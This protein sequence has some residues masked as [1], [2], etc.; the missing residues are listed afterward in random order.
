MTDD[1]SSAPTPPT[2]PEAPVAPPASGAPIPPAAPI[3]PPAPAPVEVKAHKKFLRIVV[4]VGVA[5]V[6]LALKL[7]VVAGIAGIFHHEHH[8]VGDAENAVRTFLG[9]ESDAVADTQLVGGSMSHVEVDPSCSVLKGL[10][11]GWK[12]TV[13]SS[14]KES[15]GSA[16]VVVSIVGAD[17]VS[18]H[19]VH[20]SGTWLIDSMKCA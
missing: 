9:S 18:F 7:G 1:Q 15:D 17:K 5:L 13:D 2:P 19:L 6:V 16:R 3:P 4:G 14:S 11:T 20:T 10:G 8:K 12:Y